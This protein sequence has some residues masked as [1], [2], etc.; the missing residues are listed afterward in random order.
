MNLFESLGIPHP[1]ALAPME[2]VTDISFR[3]ICKEFGA[4]LLYTEFVNADGLVR[5][6]KPTRSQTKMMITESE[7]PIAI[8]IYGG[9]LETMSEAARIIED[10]RPDFIDIN[11]GCWVRKIAGR[12]AGAGLLRDIPLMV[13]M[14]KTIVDQSK[15]PVTVKTRLGWDQESIQIVEVAKRLEDT[16]IQAL[17]IHCRTRAQGHSGTADWSWIPK[18]KD[19]ISIPILLNGDVFSAED[20]KR[21]FETTGCDGV[22]IARGAIANPWVFAEIKHYLATGEQINPPSFEE[23]VAVLLR[24]LRAAVDGKGE[25][26]AV[27]EMRKFYAGYFKRLPNSKNLR[28]ALMSKTTLHE[29]EDLLFSAAFY[30]DIVEFEDNSQPDFILAENCQ[31]K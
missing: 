23:R 7:H 11:A 1:I 17:T 22:M 13:S 18:V 30:Q 3:M 2:D 12:G 4:D 6:K 29:V 21:A 5:S 15:L 25:R 28:I 16:G 10:Q 8:Q 9:S 19:A 20:V 14:V 27:L 31:K 24:H 26:R